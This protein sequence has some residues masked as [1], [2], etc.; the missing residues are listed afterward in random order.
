MMPSTFIFLPG[1]GEATEQRLWN[2]G[3]L[4]WN[5]FL[6]TRTIPYI[7]PTRKALYDTMVQEAKNQWCLGNADYFAKLLKSRDHWRLYPHFRTNAAF[8]D[9]ET[10]GLPFPEGQITVVGILG[11]NEMTTLIRGVNLSAGALAKSLTGFDLLVTFFGSGFDLPFLRASFPGLRFDQPHL[12]L[13]FAARRL[14]MKGGLKAIEHEIGCYR[15]P[16]LNGLT[17]WDA[18]RL[19][20]EWQTGNVESRNRLIEYNQADCQNLEPLADLICDRM[21]QKYG[22]PTT[23]GISLS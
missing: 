14:G 6:E 1:I 7:S 11:R 22:P 10:N 19:W 12:D 9:I 4:D 16:L 5:T 17:G 13:C 21:G 15:P 8:L 2:T 23:M 20:K 18:V 3:I